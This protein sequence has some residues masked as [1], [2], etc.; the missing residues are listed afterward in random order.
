MSDGEIDAK[1]REALRNEG[2]EF[3]DWGADA[4]RFVTA[5]DTRDEDALALGRA[6]ARL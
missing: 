3:Y 2:F 1:E 4:A 5:W 6:I